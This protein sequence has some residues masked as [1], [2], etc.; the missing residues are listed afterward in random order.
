M[1][2]GRGQTFDTALASRT[3]SA[4]LLSTLPGP[5]VCAA[6]RSEGS[7]K[8]RGSPKR[9]SSPKACRR[10]SFGPSFENADTDTDGSDVDRPGRVGGLRDGTSAMHNGA[11]RTTELN[12]EDKARVN[13]MVRNHEERG[14][15]T[16]HHDLW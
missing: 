2:R 3:R 8:R 5:L 16:F 6:L 15:S 4:S 10:V 13:Q 7:A 9:G 14:V 12:T 11:D 1:P